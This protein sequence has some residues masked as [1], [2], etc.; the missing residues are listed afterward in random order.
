MAIQGALGWVR[1]MAAGLTLKM[2]VA[3]VM[4]ITMG[5]MMAAAIDHTG[6]AARI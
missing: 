1:S 5:R 6:D 4:T 2:L 3:A